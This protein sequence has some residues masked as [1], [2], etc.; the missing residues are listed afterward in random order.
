MRGDERIRESEDQSD[1]RESGGTS[2]SIIIFGHSLLRAR[3]TLGKIIEQQPS[4]SR[5][6]MTTLN[7]TYT[8]VHRYL[9]PRYV[10]MGNIEIDAQ[11][12]TSNDKIPIYRTDSHTK[13]T[14]RWKVWNMKDLLGGNL[15][16]TNVAEKKEG[17]V[18]L[19]SSIARVGEI[20]SGPA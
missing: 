4:I 9:L 1:N 20:Y 13:L 11:D 18:L 7:H 8:W 10:G 2:S 16:I 15:I 3:K 6:T 14:R 17:G 5:G 19:T 12:Q